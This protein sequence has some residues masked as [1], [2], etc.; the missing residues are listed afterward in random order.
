MDRM[1]KY[2]LLRKRNKKYIVTLAK[3]F[4]SSI[5]KFGSA[6]DIDDLLQ[7]ADLLLWKICA[8]DKPVEEIWKIYKTSLVNCFKD[9]L[10]LAKHKYATNHDFSV[11]GYSEGFTTTECLENPAEEALAEYEEKLFREAE[12]FGVKFNF[13]YVKQQT[14]RD[15]PR[16]VILSYIIQEAERFLEEYPLAYEIWELMKHP[17]KEFT[18]LQHRRRKT[19]ASIRWADVAEYFGVRVKSVREAREIIKY[20]FENAFDSLV[21]GRKKYS[22][23]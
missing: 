21:G 11:S 6:I 2:N 3:G 14:G 4:L 13:D 8:K 20:A 1:E 12:E 19:F 18:D 5:E 17:T 9:Q 23:W 7:D 16:Q 22:L 15:I 10:W